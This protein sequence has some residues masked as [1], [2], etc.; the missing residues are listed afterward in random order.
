MGHGLHVYVGEAIFNKTY[1]TYYIYHDPPQRMKNKGFGHLATRFICHKNLQKCRFGGPI[2]HI[3]YIQ[4][5]NIHT[6]EYIYID[7]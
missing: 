1:N 7:R 2:I 4:Y 6:Y 3:I 5:L